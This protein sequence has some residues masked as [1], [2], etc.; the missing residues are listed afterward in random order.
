MQITILG[1]GCKNCAALEA[2]T[3]EALAH[4]GIE[5]TITKV[6]DVVEIA[7]YGVMRTP[8]L[9]VDGEVVVAGRVPTVRALEEVLSSRAA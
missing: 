8:G 2:R 4:L 3:H 6:T 5:A 1:P 7:S 9:V